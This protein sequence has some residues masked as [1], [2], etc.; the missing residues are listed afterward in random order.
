MKRLF[1]LFALAIVLLSFASSSFA[2]VTASA[3]ATATIL[4]PIA[5]SKSTDMNFGNLA[6]NNTAGTVALA[7]T[8]VRTP[9]GGVTLPNPTGGPVAALFVVTG[10]VDAT[11]SITL[12]TTDY[13][14]SS[15][16]NNMTVNTFVSSPSTTGTLTLGT[17]NLS[18]GATLNVLG[19]QADGTYT[20]LTG[21]DVT[22]NYN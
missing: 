13:I 5:I 22:V 11:Y 16:A 12:P 3:T 15:G 17:S 18:V 9:S 2:Q 7:P 4:A 14:I 21:F 19:S 10:I 6:V 20:N 1:K 8:N